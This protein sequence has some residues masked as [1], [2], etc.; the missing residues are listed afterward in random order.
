MSAPAIVVSIRF[1]WV[2]VLGVP[3][4]SGHVSDFGE[5]FITISTNLLITALIVSLLIKL[6]VRIPTSKNDTDN[7]SVHLFWKNWVNAWFVMA[8]L[9]G[10]RWAASIPCF[11]KSGNIVSINLSNKI[12]LHPF[13]WT[14]SGAYASSLVGN[15]L[16]VIA[17]F[18]FFAT[19][20]A[21]KFNQGDVGFNRQPVDE[22]EAR[23]CI[24]NAY[25]SKWIKMAW[26]FVGISALLLLAT[27]ASPTPI[28]NDNPS[29][30]KEISSQYGLIIPDLIATSTFS[31][32]LMLL[33]GKLSSPVLRVPVSATIALIGYSV[34]QFGFMATDHIHEFSSY[35]PYLYAA[36]GLLKILFVLVVCWLIDTSS[37]LYYF[38]VTRALNRN[39][40]KR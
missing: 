7:D 5:T 9:Y 20:E 33:I 24:R 19:Y 32:C 21:V 2:S 11:D 26:S 15:L 14:Y 39:L 3:G 30:M 34:L 16:M 4:S 10:F 28:S 38:Q 37:M 18:F 17:S 31:L 22:S 27:A 1:F 8:I 29:S 36:A 12:A 25:S 40:A 13:S 35:S 23:G 6:T